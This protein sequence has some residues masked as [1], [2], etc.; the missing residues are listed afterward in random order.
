MADGALVVVDVVEGVHS[1]TKEVLKQAYH[2]QL[3]TILVLNKMDRLITELDLTAD[4]AYLHVLRVIEM[5]NRLHR[6]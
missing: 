5:A 1:Q 4:E 3:R 6:R 2:D